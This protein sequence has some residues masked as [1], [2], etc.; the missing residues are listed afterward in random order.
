MRCSKCGQ[1]KDPEEFPRNRNTRSGRHCYCKPCHNAQVRESRR[2]LGGSRHYHLRRRYGIGAADVD[3]MIAEQGGMCPICRKRAAV[4]VDH[5]HAT[6]K[7]R[8]IVCEL[9]NGGLGQ[10]KD[11]PEL[12]RNAIAYLERYRRKAQR[13][14]S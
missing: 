8:A 7:V 5:D 13:K 14:R 9:C 4:H 11:N 10:L 1:D 6:G 12:I 2:R 3:R